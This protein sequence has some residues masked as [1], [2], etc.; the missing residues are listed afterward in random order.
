[1]TEQYQARCPYAGM[2]MHAWGAGGRQV[3]PYLT[4]RQA[5]V[6]FT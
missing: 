5:F 4:V 2:R 3:V 1:M 6:N